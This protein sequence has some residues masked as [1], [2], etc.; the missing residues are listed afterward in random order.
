MW[1]NWSARARRV[2]AHDRC[3]RA[4]APGAARATWVESSRA[5]ASF[6][7]SAG[8]FVDICQ[9]VSDWKA[10]RF[11][12]P[13]GTSRE[14][15]ESIYV[16]FMGTTS[17]SEE[18]GRLRR[19]RKTRGCLADSRI[20]CLRGRSAILN[21]RTVRVVALEYSQLHKKAYNFLVCGFEGFE[22]ALRG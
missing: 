12:W 3:A 21:L 15:V 5:M 6:N 19:R 2:R 8:R 9:V 1:R 18:L 17:L 14:S 7:D 11:S 16:K 4:R 13:K 22:S 10:Q 20:E